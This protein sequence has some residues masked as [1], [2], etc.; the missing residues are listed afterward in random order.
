MATKTAAFVCPAART[1]SKQARKPKW[2]VPLVPVG[3]RIITSI[4]LF[5]F[6]TEIIGRD[7]DDD[8]DDDEACVFLKKL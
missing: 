4:L 6:A 7:D 2:Y 8:D 3:D 5:A 1:T